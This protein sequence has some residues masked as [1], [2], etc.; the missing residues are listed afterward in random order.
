MTTR[1]RLL[2]TLVFLGRGKL[3]MATELLILRLDILILT[4]LGTL[5]VPY[6][7]AILPALAPRILLLPPMFIGLF[8]KPRAMFILIVLRVPIVKKSRRHITPP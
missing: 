5:I 2:V 7:M 1:V 3:V 8:I 4:S 6:P